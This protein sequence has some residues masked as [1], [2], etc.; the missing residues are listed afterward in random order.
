MLIGSKAIPLVRDYVLNRV[1]IRVIGL[2]G[3]NFFSNL[4]VV[5][6]S[7]VMNKMVYLS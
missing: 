1:I 3:K 5:K 7:F 6:L 2:D 4:V